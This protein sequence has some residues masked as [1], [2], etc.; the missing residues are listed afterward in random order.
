MFITIVLS[1]FSHQSILFFRLFYECLKI[2]SFAGLRVSSF[3]LTL[4]CPL[5]ALV[6]KNRTYCTRACDKSGLNVVPHFDYD[7]EIE[8]FVCGMCPFNFC[9]TLIVSL[10]GGNTKNPFKISCQFLSVIYL[11]RGRYCNRI[12]MNLSKLDYDNGYDGKPRI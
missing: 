12:R 6:F 9:N 3:R 2:N 11:F 10:W 7:N 1:A 4:Q 8:F 5:P